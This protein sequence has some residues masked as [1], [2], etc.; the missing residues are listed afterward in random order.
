MSPRA[1]A[2]YN[3]LMSVRNIESETPEYDASCDRLDVLWYE[4]TVSEA[5]EVEDKLKEDKLST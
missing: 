5:E 4:M 1:Q 2:Y 3:E